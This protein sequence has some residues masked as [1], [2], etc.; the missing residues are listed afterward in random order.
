MTE[1]MASFRQIIIEDAYRPLRNIA[2]RSFWRHKYW[3][4]VHSRQ[5]RDLTADTQHGRLTFSSKDKFIGWSLYTAGHYGYEDLSVSV[6]ILKSQ[7]KLADHNPG[8]LIDIG[9]NIGTVCIPLVRDSVFKRALAFEPEP[10]NFG[11]L[12]RNIEQNDLSE[13][14]R[15]F[16]I[17][18]SAT[19]GEVEF[20]LCPENR[21]D[22]RVR[23][24]APLTDYNYFDE[25]GRSVIKVPARTLDEMIG[26]LEIGTEEINLLWMDV[27]GHE[28]HV[29]KGAQSL[30]ASGV[31]VVFEFWPYGLQSAGLD[32]E[33]FID[34]VSSRFT[35]L[36]DLGA[37]KPEARPASYIRELCKILQNGTA[38][39]QTDLLVF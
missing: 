26:S 11:Y 25:K 23:L 31:P 3:N 14:V 6:D 16:Q 35:Q 32:L 30:L 7:G 24:S 1:E 5:E 20:E 15:P 21:G 33:W 34:F 4:F 8:Y 18:L 38:V 29:L 12:T 22:H 28:G 39:A 36:W 2:T 13:R 27:Q 19:S 37:D 9:A 17:A 10:R